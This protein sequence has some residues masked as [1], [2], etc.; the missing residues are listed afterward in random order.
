M[1]TTVL[2]AV[3]GAA[4][5]HASWNVVVKAGVSKVGGIAMMTVVQG[6][7]GGV[8]I[9][10]SPWPAA[11]VWPWL[12]A[13]G[14][15]HAGYKLFL[16]FAY[17]HGDLSRVYP[18][19][20]GAAPMIVLLVGPLILTDALSP[21]EVLGIV[22]LGCGIATMAAGALRA[23]EARRL[24]PYALGSAAMTAGYTIVDGSGARVAASAAQYV[25]WLFFLDM[26]IFTPLM[27]A[28]RGRAIFPGTLRAWAPGALAA[29]LSYLAY[30]VAVWAMTEA[31]IA[32]VG[33]LRE[34]SI[35][36]AVLLGWLLLGERV[37]RWKAIAAVLIVAGVALTRL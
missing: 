34:T 11:A 36:F 3:L 7:A 21:Q 29:L 26:L 18:I 16:A 30:A 19:A 24:I 13:S 32:L 31:P 35:L 10:A 5:L 17:E 6:I 8:V 12:V 22:V 28:L 15:F 9:L 25:G 4:L 27:V 33:A 23:R 20:R 37:D 1:S 14:V 2:L